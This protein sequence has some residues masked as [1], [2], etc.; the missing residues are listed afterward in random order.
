MTAPVL[1]RV[2]GFVERTPDAIALEGNLGSRTYAELV[3]RVA[4]RARAL[5]EK[6]IGLE[7]RVALCLTPSLETVEIMLAVMW[8]GAAFIPLD[9]NSPP[10]RIT[11]MLDA[12][13]PELVIAKDGL[14][15]WEPLA[16]YP[17]VGVTALA[18]TPAEPSAVPPVRMPP[19]ALAYVV[20]T[21]GSTG[22][23]KGVMVQHTG[24]L[25]MVE[26]QIAT[27]GLGAA[28]RQLQFASLTFDASV[29]EV[30]TTLCAGA[31]LVL[32]EHPRDRQ[33]LALVDFLAS[34]RISVVTFPPTLLRALP[35]RDLP[36]IK[37]LISAGEACTPD[38]VERW[39]RPGRT[40][41][42]A[43]GPTETTVC[44][45][46]KIM[47]QPADAAT[48]GGAIGGL[49]V[50]VL[51][52][53]LAQI[54]AAGVE[55][56][57]YIGGVGVARGYINQPS[58][59]AERF[60]PDPWSGNAGAR[61]YRTGDRVRWNANRDLEYLGR[62]DDQVKVRGFRIEL[63]EVEASLRRAPGVTDVLVQQRRRTSGDALLVAY[64]IADSAL[65]PSLRVF[66]RRELA[67][68]MQPSEYV[69]VESWPR[70]PSD[71]IDRKALAALEPKRS[72]AGG[73]G[74]SATENVLLGIFAQLLEL[75]AVGR[76]DSFFDLGGDSI[77]AMR[78]LSRID[79]QLARRI[80]VSTLFERPTVAALARWLDGGTSRDELPILTLRD[81]DR[82]HPI[83]FIPPVHGN[84][85]CYFELARRMAPGDACFGLQVPGLDDDA[86]P[87]DN[88]H[89]LAK[90]L[91]SIVRKVQPQGPYRLVGW[92]LGGTVAHHMSVELQ[93]QEA[94]V[95]A[96]VMIAATPPTEVHFVEA[97]QVLGEYNVW[98]ICH[99]YGSQMSFST[100][101][102][103]DLPAH[104]AKY[105]DLDDARAIAQLT[106][107]L[108]QKGMFT[109]DLTTAEVGRWV[110]VFQA[111]LRGF[112]YTDATTKYRG[113][114]LH[115]QTMHHNPFHGTPMVDRKLPSGDW[116]QHV[117][118]LTVWKIPGDHLNLMTRPW[119]DGVAD[120]LDRWLASRR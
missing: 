81:G 74:G 106:E 46:M 13:R 95:S 101:G 70:L 5:A 32:V 58:L 50:H 92:S 71:K 57:L 11:A 4:G 41:V 62:A 86:T 51:D 20:F 34:R 112:H 119:V 18:G 76:D 37:T 93:R 99:M 35:E 36:D 25:N 90:H 61:M 84:S 113:N 88:L 79:V 42:N 19:T 56:E 75:P 80:P 52:D 114:A 33:G 15:E 3:R 21:S 72:T 27:F 65:E 17:R 100:G 40:M 23:P 87:F 47:R 77:L 45:T 2:L 103:V 115:I 7:S 96:L 73:T 1:Q 110:R 97:R 98:K 44:A 120:A 29:A 111:S 6:G 108:G 28:S 55:G 48:I 105:K 14:V 117:E 118:Q 60:L 54:T 24:L 12:A 31:T 68:F 83:W 78:L 8:A 94:E 116:L 66:A 85:L 49:A 59:S 102:R 30:F 69:F 10:G 107:E 64:V 43:Y 22:T 82:A 67:E 9:P 91:V 38:V 104:Y 16:R 39:L 109:S 53:N 26:Q 89:A 63:G